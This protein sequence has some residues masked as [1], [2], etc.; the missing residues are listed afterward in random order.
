MQVNSGDF[1]KTPH[2]VASDLV[3]NYLPMSK[4][5]DVMHI[6]VKMQL[7]C[8]QKREVYC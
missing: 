6:S 4:K 7:F 1:D 5:K 3:L 2:N 8:L